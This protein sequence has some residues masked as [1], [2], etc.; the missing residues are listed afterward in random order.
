MRLFVKEHFIYKCK[1]MTLKCRKINAEYFLTLREEHTLRVFEN[2]VLKRIFGH[3]REEVAGRWRSV[4]NVGGF[5]TRTLRC[6]S[7]GG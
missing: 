6:S 5:I 1:R 2:R 7:Q 4:H 3:K